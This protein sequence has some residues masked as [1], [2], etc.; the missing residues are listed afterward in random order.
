M[1][2]PRRKFLKGTTSPMLRVR[3]STH[4][5]ETIRGYH[6]TFRNLDLQSQQ[7]KLMQLVVADSEH[8]TVPAG[9]FRLKSGDQLNAWR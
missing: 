9:T 4:F 5:L 1:P 2:L 8:V 3:S 6:T 7:P